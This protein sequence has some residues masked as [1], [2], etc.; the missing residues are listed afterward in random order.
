ILKIAESISTQ[1][2]NLSVQKG[3]VIINSNINPEQEFNIEVTTP[4]SIINGTHV[5]LNVEV[6]KY[7]TLISVQQGEVTLTEKTTLQEINLIQ[8]QLAIVENNEIKK[9]D[10]VAMNENQNS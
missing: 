3:K 6:N 4:N 10:P 5:L 9:Y 7:R 1:V 8:G 2:Q